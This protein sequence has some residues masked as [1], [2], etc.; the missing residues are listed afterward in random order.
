MSW[1]SAASLSSVPETIRKCRGAILAFDTFPLGADPSQ[2][3]VTYTAEPGSFSQDALSPLANW[4]ATADG[5]WQPS[6]TDDAQQR[7]TAVDRAPGLINTE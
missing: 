3:L 4:S 1:A 6:S 5:N 7:E 2:T